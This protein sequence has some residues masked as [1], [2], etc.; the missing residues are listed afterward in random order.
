MFPNIILFFKS[1]REFDQ[2]LA[3]AGRPTEAKESRTGP[4]QR[5]ALLTWRSGEGEH[6]L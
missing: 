1:L 4:E 5:L 2:F 3:D 6:D